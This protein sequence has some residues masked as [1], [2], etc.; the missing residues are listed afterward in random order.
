ML[1]YNNAFINLTNKD[2]LSN[3]MEIYNER[4]MNIKYNTT[5]IATFPMV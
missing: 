3:N 5:Y 4:E 2:T 1:E